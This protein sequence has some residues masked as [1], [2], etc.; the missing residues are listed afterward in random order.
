LSIILVVH[1]VKTTS[2][3]EL[4]AS[5]HAAQPRFFNLSTLEARYGVDAAA[6]RVLKPTPLVVDN[7]STPSLSSASQTPSNDDKNDVDLFYVENGLGHGRLNRREHQQQH[8]EEGLTGEEYVGLVADLHYRGG[9]LPSSD[10]VVVAVAVVVVAAAAASAAVIYGKG[11]YTHKESD[12][13]ETTL[14]DRVVC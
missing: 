3:V 6:V 10:T 7:P 9:L 12:M 13:T 5:T 14:L 11:T 2:L 1:D 8:K 4:L